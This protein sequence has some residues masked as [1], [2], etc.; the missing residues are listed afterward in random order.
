LL[1][2]QF[3]QVGRYAPPQITSTP[4]TT[5][6][7]GQLYLYQ[8][9]V[10]AGISGVMPTGGLVYG[11]TQYPA[12]MTIDPN[13]G[14]VQWSPSDFGTYPVTIEVQDVMGQSATQSY[15]IAVAPTAA[16]LPPVITTVPVTGAT[17]TVPYTQP[18]TAVDPQ[19]GTG[20]TQ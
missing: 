15:T 8:V 2:G 5:G 17:F 7:V 3:D 9:G 16:A 13:T 11:L 4:P 18:I 1:P 6:V 10:T 19:N 12:G 20:E 14:A